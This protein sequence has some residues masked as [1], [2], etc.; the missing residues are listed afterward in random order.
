MRMV[1]K[2]GGIDQ[3][4]QRGRMMS[5]QITRMTSIKGLYKQGRELLPESVQKMETKEKP[6]VRELRMRAIR[7]FLEKQH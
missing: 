2:R 1:L 3:T 7:S 5:L 4:L 6:F